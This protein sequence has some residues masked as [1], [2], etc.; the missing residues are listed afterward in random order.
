[1]SKCDGCVNFNGVR[2]QLLGTCPYPDVTDF[3]SFT[4]L[5]MG[6]GSPLRDNKNTDMLNRITQLENTVKVLVECVDTL[7]AD[8][9]KKPVKVKE[10]YDPSKDVQPLIRSR[11][12]EGRGEIPADTKPPRTR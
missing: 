4:G 3:K 7:L 9:L 2:C 8:K 1:M 11:C 5:T 12:H 6:K 10:E